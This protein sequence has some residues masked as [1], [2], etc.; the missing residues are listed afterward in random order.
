MV[1]VGP[2]RVTESWKYA[3]FGG[4]L[5]LPFTVLEVL[6]SPESITLEMFVGG[7]VLAGYLIKRDGGNSTVTGLRSALIGGFPV[8]WILPEMLRTVVNI[9]NPPWFQAVSVLI[10]FVFGG[11]VIA[12]LAVLGA[13]AGRF[14]GWIAEW[15]GY[16]GLANTD[17]SA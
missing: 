12:L 7:S 3:L 11:L 5:A 4:L 2:L 15:R 14:G 17:G 13:L 10:L 1:Q 6:Q 9:S 16:G 8:I